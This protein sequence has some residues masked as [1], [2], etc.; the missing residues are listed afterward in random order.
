MSEELQSRA[1]KEALKAEALQAF[2]GIKLLHIKREVEKLLGLIGREGFFNEFT[3]HDISHI[4]EMLT[5]LD[6]LVPESTKKIMTP[7][8]WLLTV[9]AV[10][11]HDLGMLVT[12]SE[13][14]QRNKSDFQSFLNNVLY[15]GTEGEDYRAKVS[16]RYVDID[17]RER[18]LYQEFVRHTHATRIYH[19]I[20]GD[21]A[22]SY[23]FSEGALQAV[24]E[25]L[26][27]LDPKFRKDLA[28]VCQSHHESDLDDTSK[29]RISQ[30]YGNKP[31]ET[32]NL[33]YVAIL[34]RTA[35]L[36]HITKDRTPSILFR[37]INPADPVS[38]VE[39]AKQMAVKSVRAK[40]RRDKDGLPNEDLEKDTIEVH[41][42]FT[43][44]DGF[45]GLTS[46]LTYADKEIKRSHEW[47]EQSKRAENSKYNF[48]WR[49]IDDSNIEASGFL[50]KP[51]SF[52][53]DQTKILDLL[54]GHTLYNDTAVV[55]RELVQNALDAIKLQEIDESSTGRSE[56]KGKVEMTWDSKDRVLTVQD[57][58]T[59]MTQE[60]IENHLL[61]VGS[62]RYQ[63][64][65]FK[66]QFPSFS[67]ISRFGIGVL[68]CFMIADDVEIYT[69]HPDEPEGRH[70]SLRT[71]HGR[72][73]IRL[74][75]KHT[76]SNLTS[77]GQH[78]TKIILKVRHS[79]KE[80]DILRNAEQWIVFPRCEVLVKL[81]NDKPISI[82]YESPREARSGPQKA[83]SSFS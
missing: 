32:V 5:I 73:L 60:V 1:E 77:I 43:K 29:Y 28:I 11:F 68:S 59:G 38:Q 26:N 64:P 74:L 25:L 3:R 44:A 71:V 18:F 20:A 39:W 22:P 37:V 27:S 56:F 79:A 34:L 21:V 66:K 10:Y 13:F 23:G 72:Y 57:N 4:D 61:K 50:P 42:Y 7:A 17:S 54:T 36:L 24:N 8:D 80:V 16:E 62:S 19:W 6:W 51:F 55:L 9:L 83:V 48:P 40:I 53:L 65:E 82:G 49:S 67:A 76:D 12:K 69:S 45:F 78:G 63:S 33:Q 47:V 31:E 70:L 15:I 58:G 35:D 46:Y 14:E 30:P 81:D 52:Q 75:N 41:A 2:S